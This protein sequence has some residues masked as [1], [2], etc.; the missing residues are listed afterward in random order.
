MLG[1]NQPDQDQQQVERLLRGW[2]VGGASAPAMAHFP[3]SWQPL[4]QEIPPER[5]TLMALALYSQYQSLLLASH[6][7]VPLQA[8]PDLPD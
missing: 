7:R 6:S 2:I 4:M 8:T 3:P 5:K 1:S